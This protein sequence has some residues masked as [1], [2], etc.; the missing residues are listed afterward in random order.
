MS[1]L[2]ETLS[3]IKTAIANSI[4]ER[5]INGNPSPVNYVGLLIAAADEIAESFDFME[6]LE[7]ITNVE[8]QELG[9]GF[10][11]EESDLMLFPLWL[12]PFIP[13]GTELRNISGDPVIKGEDDVDIWAG[14]W[15][16]MGI[17]ID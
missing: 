11:N 17:I 4:G 10:L 15:I 5:L 3:V 2:Y 7:F 8:L 13:D 9:F 6:E 12:Y 14:S 1:N 16:N